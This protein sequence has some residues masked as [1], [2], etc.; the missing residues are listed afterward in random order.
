MKKAL[1]DEENRYFT[2]RNGEIVVWGADDV[3]MLLEAANDALKHEYEVIEKDGISVLSEDGVSVASTSQEDIFCSQIHDWISRL[4]DEGVTE[5][6]I[7]ELNDELAD[8]RYVHVL[9]PSKKGV[10]SWQYNIADLNGEFDIE[11]AAAYAF[12]QQLAI[13]AFEGIKRCQLP[14]C[15]KFF[16]GRPNAKWCSPS[17][18]S[19]FRVRKK[20]KRDIR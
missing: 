13:G 8:I 6:L 17:C 16:I 3:G 4:V 20:R 14:D 7:D 2:F 10:P 9:M 15:E 19:K 11:E 5:E 12:S 18:G 1:H